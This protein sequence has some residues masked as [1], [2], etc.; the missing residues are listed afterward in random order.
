MTPIQRTLLAIAAFVTIAV[1]TFIYFIANWDASKAEPIGM[2]K[3]RSPFILPNKL[4][5]LGQS[6][7]PALSVRTP[8]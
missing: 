2:M 3:E 4:R 7:S 5:G 6:P 1:G 8:A